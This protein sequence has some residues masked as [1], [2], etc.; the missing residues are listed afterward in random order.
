MMPSMRA[1]LCACLLVVAC[2]SDKAA[3]AATEK[4]SE[5]S[6]TAHGGP[7]PALPDTP[8][9]QRGERPHLANEPEPRNWNDPTMRERMEERR[10]AREKALDTNHDGVV[11]P[12]ERR[13]RLKPM[14]DRLDTNGDGKLTPE[15]LSAAQGHMQF[16]DPAAIDT[17]HN[18]EISLSELDTAV[19]QR[20]AEMRA[21][22]RGRNGGSADVGSGQ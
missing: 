16:G 9:S 13:A 15:E 21:K 20:R 22:W 10:A 1:L 8:E 17:D 3:P 4:K 7:T 12:E 19:T 5:S 11:S 14:V 6:Q 2:K 18:G